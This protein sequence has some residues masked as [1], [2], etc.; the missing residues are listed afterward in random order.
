MQQFSRLR[1]HLEYRPIKWSPFN[2]SS[3]LANTNTDLSSRCQLCFIPLSS[4]LNQSPFVLFVFSFALSPFSASL[5]LFLPFGLYFMW[6]RNSCLVQGTRLARQAGC[7]R[8][9]AR[10]LSSLSHSLTHAR[11]HAQTRSRPFM[12]I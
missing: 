4:L 6:Q 12:P 8:C 1:Y 9:R 7:R 11:T 2:Q 10:T 5:A 3:I